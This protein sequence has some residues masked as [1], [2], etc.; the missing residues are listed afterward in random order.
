MKILKAVAIALVLVFLLGIGFVYGGFFNVAADD[1][2][3]GITSRLI[4]STRERSIS[5]GARAVPAPPALDDPQLIAIGAGHYAE[6]CTGCHLAPGMAETDIRVGL[7]P[8]PPNLA[9]RGRQRS[10]E[11]TFWIIKHG[12]KMSGMPAWGVTHDDRTIW[13]LAAFVMQLHRMTAEQYRAAIQ[14]KA[15]PAPSPEHH[16]EHTHDEREH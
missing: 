11:E 6:M 4:E 10:P 7:Y 2:H 16:Y 3:W 12:L 8:K 5:A 14:R 9:R 15:S 13:G 1:P